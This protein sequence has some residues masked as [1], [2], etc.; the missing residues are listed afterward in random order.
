[1]C[2]DGPRFP[3]NSCNGK[4]V[5]ARFFSAGAQAA[6]NINLS[7]DLLSSF[8]TVGHGSH[9][10]ATAAGNYDIPVVVN[11]FN[12]GR[13]SGMAPRASYIF[14]LPCYRLNQKEITRSVFRKQD[15]CLQGNI[16]KCW[17]SS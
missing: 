17:N 12:Y 11:G 2:E 9:V 13:A 14:E 7:I 16:P 3:L 4:I 10:A 6:A 5:S 1:V 8:D 15:C